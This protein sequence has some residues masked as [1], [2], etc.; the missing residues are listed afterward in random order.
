[1]LSGPI[2]LASEVDNDEAIAAWRKPPFP[3]FPPFPPCLNG[4][5]LVRRLTILRPLPPPFL[6]FFFLPAP[7]HGRVATQRK[8]NGINVPTPT[9]PF[10]LLISFTTPHA[11]R[12]K[13]A[14]RQQHA[15]ILSF[16]S[17]SFLF[18]PLPC[19]I[20]R[21]EERQAAA[22]LPFT[23]FLYFS[24]IALVRSEMVTKLIGR[25]SE[26]LFFLFPPIFSTSLFSPLPP[27]FS[28]V[29]E[30]MLR[31]VGEKNDERK[32]RFPP[33]P[34]PQSSFFPSSRSRERDR[35]R[36]HG[37]PTAGVVPVLFRPFSFLKVFFFFPFL[38][39]PAAGGGVD[40]G[41]SQSAPPS[42][43]LSFFFFYQNPPL[44]PS[45]RLLL[46]VWPRKFGG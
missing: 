17:F 44:P 6:R 3:L 14:R 40:N 32:D 24:L 31:R 36:R 28:S 33:F 38:L 15:V 35:H 30:K 45:L 8:K 9:L 11:R 27:P 1:V 41:L 26:P 23:S 13:R 16:P 4:Q 25:I 2:L 12:G 5:R 19:L 20:R 22:L 46:L 43:P 37:K 42:L 10:S 21:G 39:G 34:F 7:P 29:I 18:F